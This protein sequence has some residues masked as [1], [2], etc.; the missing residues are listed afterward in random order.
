MDAQQIYEESIRMARES[1]T[2]M[3]HIKWILAC[4][5]LQMWGV[6]VYFLLKEIPTWWNSFDKKKNAKPNTLEQR[7]KDLAAATRPRKVWDW[8]D[9]K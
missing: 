1:H 9:P 2:N 5:A 4:M 6:T 3:V 8:N 7:N